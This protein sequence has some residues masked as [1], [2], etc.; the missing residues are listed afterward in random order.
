[1][2]EGELVNDV[3]AFLLISRVEFCGQMKMS[4]IL[5]RRGV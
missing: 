4:L 1:M 3:R 5:G 2:T